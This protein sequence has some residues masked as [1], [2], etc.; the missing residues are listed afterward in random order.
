MSEIYIFDDQFDPEEFDGGDLKSNTCQN[1][2]NGIFKA[3]LGL[4]IPFFEPL[5]PHT[6]TDHLTP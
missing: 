5:V 2:R 1:I 3:F 6:Y 4:K